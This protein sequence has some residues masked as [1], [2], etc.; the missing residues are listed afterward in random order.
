MIAAAGLDLGDDLFGSTECAGFFRRL[1]I[2]ALPAARPM[3]SGVLQFPALTLVT[4][5]MYVFI[6][7]MRTKAWLMS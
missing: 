7:A 2:V 6:S 4:A 3:A 5:S 1:G